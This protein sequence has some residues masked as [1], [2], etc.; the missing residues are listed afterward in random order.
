M[1]EQAGAARRGTWG[2]GC[3]GSAKRGAEIEKP[4]K[5]AADGAEG[6]AESTGLLTAAVTGAEEATRDEASARERARGAERAVKGDEPAEGV[7]EGAKGG[8][9]TTV[10]SA[11]DAKKGLEEGREAEEGKGKRGALVETTEVAK[12][13]DEGAET[14][15]TA[16]GA[17][18]GAEKS[19]GIEGT[20]S[21][22]TREVV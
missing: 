1:R 4:A 11:G 21:E 12:K 20:A 6:V 5:K 17:A 19:T 16:T 18:E 7:V 15:E 2:A 14:E 13:G 8:E 22:A 10:E 9:I 3:A